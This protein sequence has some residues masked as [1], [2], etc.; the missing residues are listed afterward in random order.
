[1]RIKVLQW[2]IWYQENVNNILE[3]IRDIDPDIFCLQ[4]LTVNA[5]STHWIDVPV[6]IAQ[7][8]KTYHAYHSA[9]TNKQWESIGNGIFSKYPLG[10]SEYFFVTEGKSGSDDYSDE[11]RVCVSTRVLFP[12]GKF[13]DIA[14]THLS[15]TH[16]FEEIPAKKREVQN[17][18]QYIQSRKEN[19]LITGDFNLVPDAVSF[20]QIHSQFQSCWPSYDQPSWT[21]KP[22][23]YN[24]FVATERKWRLD[25]VFSTHD[26]RVIHSE[27]IETPYSDHLPLLVEI[28]I[29]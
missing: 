29:P 20:Q 19:F 14:T 26:I 10:D 7:H 25:Y 3:L 28:E 22:F 2:N 15:Y 16:A 27:I 11:W 8:T 17:L 23:S 5:E 24:G 13:L 21:T 18:S 9:H 4:E 6:Y 12:Q 1:M